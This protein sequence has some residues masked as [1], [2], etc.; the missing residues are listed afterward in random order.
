M[1]LPTY[2]SLDIVRFFIDIKSYLSF[3]KTQLLYLVWFSLAGILD[4]VTSSIYLV[5][6]Y[7]TNHRLPPKETNF[8]DKPLFRFTVSLN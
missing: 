8:S 7:V 6:Q 3:I 2:S 5:L 4:D 1:A